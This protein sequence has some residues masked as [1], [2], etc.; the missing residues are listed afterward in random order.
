MMLATIHLFIIQITIQC[1]ND[2]II[3]LTSKEY[4]NWLAYNQTKHF[5]K[6]LTKMYSLLDLKN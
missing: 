5:S 1:L 6:C 3:I 2:Y 4:Y